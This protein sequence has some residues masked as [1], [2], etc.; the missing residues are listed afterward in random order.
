VVDFG[1]ALVP[2][3]EQGPKEV[4]QHEGDGQAAAEV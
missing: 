1:D 4:E 3:G 2:E